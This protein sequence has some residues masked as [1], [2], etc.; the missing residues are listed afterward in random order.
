[1]YTCISCSRT[2]RVACVLK[3]PAPSHCRETFVFSVQA[4]VFEIDPQT[5]KRWLPSSAN[6]VRVAYYHD[7]ARKT[8]RIIAIESSKVMRV[9]CVCCCD[10][11]YCVTH[12]S[13]QCH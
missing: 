7:S 12:G 4:H 5:K 1:M 9:V 13:G 11:K 8:F 6:A 10:S 2:W 3:C